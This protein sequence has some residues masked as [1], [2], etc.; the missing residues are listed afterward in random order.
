MA[1]AVVLTVVVFAFSGIVKI[2]GVKASLE[3]RDALGVSPGLWR[4]I[5][6]LE[7]LG[8]LGIAGA[9]VG[10]LPVWLGQAAA[11][12]FILLILGAITTR[13]RAKSPVGLLLMDLVTLVLAVL[14][15]VVL[16][17]R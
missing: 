10:V 11:V 4:T 2:A 7:L 6:V 9:W 5:G 13:I 1:F 12:G 8:V 16:R 3:Q 14:T 17:S 15:L